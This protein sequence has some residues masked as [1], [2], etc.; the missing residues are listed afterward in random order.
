MEMLLSFRVSPLNY[1]QF[2][3]PTV[4]ASF[5]HKRLSRVLLFYLDIQPRSAS[6]VHWL[7]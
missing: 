7:L 6:T 2:R 3:S 5:P 4:P 1:R